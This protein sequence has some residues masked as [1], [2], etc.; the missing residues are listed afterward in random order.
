[1]R[2]TREDVVVERW[3][4][5]PVPA[6]SRLLT[7]CISRAWSMFFPPPGK[8]ISALTSLQNRLGKKKAR[9]VLQVVL[10]VR[11]H[12][13]KQSLTEWTRVRIQSL[14]RYS[15]DLFGLTFSQICTV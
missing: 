13:R 1:M 11:W 8:E 5:R 3:R 6:L 4:G 2:E 9:E 10:D 12:Q 14:R 7:A 15:L